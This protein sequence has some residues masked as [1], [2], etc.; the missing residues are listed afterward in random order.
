[1]VKA[2]ESED[3]R[4][5]TEVYEAKGMRLFSLAEPT[6]IGTLLTEFTAQGEVIR[7]EYRKSRDIDKELSSFIGM[8]IEKEAA[9][10]YEP[11]RLNAV[12]PRCGG[13]LVRELDTKAP[14]EIGEVPVVPLF[15]CNKCG[16]HYY[17][18]HREFLAGIVHARPDLFEAEELE[19][20]KQDEH[21][22]LDRLEA[23]IIRIF[24]SRRLFRINVKEKE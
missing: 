20:L 16:T 6:K 14:G 21:E 3:R 11:I 23:T 19:E 7:Q 24:A 4:I 13:E 2:Y 8:R 5:R 15:V 9:S 1:M 22:F 17:T 18:L 12:C 10:A